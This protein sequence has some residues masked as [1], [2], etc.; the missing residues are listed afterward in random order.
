LI[1]CREDPEAP[2][3]FCEW[4]ACAL[5]ITPLKSV[6][7]KPRHSVCIEK[8]LDWHCALS[9]QSWDAALAV[10]VSHSN[11]PPL[12]R[13]AWAACLPGPRSRYLGTLVALEGLCG[14][15]VIS[16]QDAAAV[17][18][19]LTASFAE[20]PVLQYVPG[21]GP[22]G[23]SQADV[24]SYLERVLPGS[25][26]APPSPLLQCRVTWTGDIKDALKSARTKCRVVVRGTGAL[27]GS[28]LLLRGIELKPL[29]AAL[30]KGQ[31]TLGDVLERMEYEILSGLLELDAERSKGVAISISGLQVLCPPKRYRS[32]VQINGYNAWPARAAA[33]LGSVAVS[34]LKILGGWTDESDGPETLAPN[35]HFSN[36]LYHA[37]ASSVKLGASGLRCKA[38]TLLQ[39]NAGGCV[40][41]GCRGLLPARVKDMAASGI[42]IHRICQAT[43]RTCGQGALVT[44]GNV[45]VGGSVQTCTV[46]QVTVPYLGG[47]RFSEAVQGPNVYWRVCEVGFCP[48]ESTRSTYMDNIR[49]LG[50]SPRFAPIGPEDSWFLFYVK[51]QGPCEDAELGD[52]YL[53][54]PVSASALEARRTHCESACRV[55]TLPQDPLRRDYF[56]CANDADPSLGVDALWIQGKCG[57]NVARNVDFV[58]VKPKKLVCPKRREVA[59][60]VAVARC[61]PGS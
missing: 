15:C 60:E 21:T 13:P 50:I 35:S 53:T 10:A 39:G 32:A 23:A 40:N 25:A 49:L 4:L 55:Y 37:A 7:R 12:T 16:I 19:P 56:V 5:V 22:P 27:D 59:S 48:G 46:S 17:Q 41:I 34:D 44:S 58:R 29:H 47:A 42:F 43:E 51:S 52:V 36:C 20:L 28:R 1:P 3:A 11:P 6:R 18:I 9:A 30:V 45:C 54:L 14:T 57:L 2:L 61:G 26:S 24:D 38:I 33:P 8:T 31:V